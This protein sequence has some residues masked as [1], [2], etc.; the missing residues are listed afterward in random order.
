[1][2]VVDHLFAYGTLRRTAGH[3]AHELL[4]RCSTFVG[5]GVVS[6]RMFDLGSYPGIVL[7]DEPADRVIGDVYLLAADCSESV[8]A[9]L[10]NYEGVGL[11]HPAPHEYVRQPVDVRMADGRSIEA[12]AYVL[13]DAFPA[14]PR[15]LTWPETHKRD[16]WHR[17]R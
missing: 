5:E 15:I 11:E 16:S 6:A 8:L 12:W 10:D 1:M 14:R 17:E 2:A 9:R 3:A 13:V 4:A 7:S